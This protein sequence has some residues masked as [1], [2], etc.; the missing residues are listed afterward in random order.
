MNA[1]I[2]IMNKD[3]AF[4][5]VEILIVILII[6]ILAAIVVPK[7]TDIT[8][9]ARLITTEKNLGVLKRVIVLYRADYGVYPNT[10]ADLSP[11]YIQKIP[12]E[13]KSSIIGSNAVFNTATE[14]EFCETNIS[15]WVYANFDIGTDA[16]HGRLVRVGGDTLEWA[17]GEVIPDNP[18][19]MV[20]HPTMPQ[21]PSPH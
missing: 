11:V 8:A 16:P 1:I 4:T 6:G 18:L 7:I 19:C 17:G 14:Q 21:E 13:L 3:N 12:K 2:C 5:L 10:L 15:G 9:K 20:C